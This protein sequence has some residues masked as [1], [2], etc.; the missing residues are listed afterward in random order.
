[1]RRVLNFRQEGVDSN[2]T[3][4]YRNTHTRIQVLPATFEGLEGFKTELDTLFD[5]LTECRVVGVLG[6]VGGVDG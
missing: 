1:M 4:S 6:G 5:V 3:P 2:T